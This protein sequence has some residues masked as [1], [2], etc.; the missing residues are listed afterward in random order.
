MDNDHQRPLR[1]WEQLA[2]RPA[3]AAGFPAAQGVYDPACEH[4]SCGVGMLAH[5]DAKPRHRLVQQAIEVLVNLEH[6]GALGGDRATGDGAG[7]LLQLPDA[8]FRSGAGLTFALPPAGEYG[9][10]MVFLPPVAAVATRCR[11]ELEKA[12]A[13]HGLTVL[14]WRRAL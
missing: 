9:V 8:F 7:V 11:G 4:D 6:R 3:N 14:G 2:F 1:G 5:L 13:A 10:G 12:A